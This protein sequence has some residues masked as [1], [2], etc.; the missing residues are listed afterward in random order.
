MPGSIRIE[1][2]QPERKVF[3]A[4]IPLPERAALHLVN[5]PAWQIR[6]NGQRAVSESDSDSAQMSIRLPAGMSRVE[7][8]F[9]R[10]PDRAIGAALSV[11]AML[12]WVELM[13]V[14]LKDER[15]KAP[16]PA[17]RNALEN[18]LSA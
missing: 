7:V 6:I 17:D 16:E 11:A 18:Q 2:W 9:G 4:D 1:S 10:T 5:Y 8:S 14:M 12:I 3:S 15:R 13:A